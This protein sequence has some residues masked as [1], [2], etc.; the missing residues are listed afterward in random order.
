MLPRN[1]VGTLAEFLGL[2]ME[3]YLSA[4]L[5][6]PSPSHSS[7]DRTQSQ[8]NYIRGQGYALRLNQDSKKDILSGHFESSLL[9]LSYLC[10]C[11]RVLLFIVK[12]SIGAM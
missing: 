9:S 7:T 5:A 2:G 1:T 4:S 12:M 11:V 3:W 10:V 8:K 6:L